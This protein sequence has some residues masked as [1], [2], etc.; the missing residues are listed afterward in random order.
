MACKNDK[1]QLKM[2]E[3]KITVPSFPK[4]KNYLTNILQEMLFKA[5]IGKR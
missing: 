5:I 3:S 2:T 1:N 4:E